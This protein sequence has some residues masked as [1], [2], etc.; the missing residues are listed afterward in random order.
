ALGMPLATPG[1][2]FLEGWPGPRTAYAAP[3]AVAVGGPRSPLLG[4]K[5][6]A[7]QLAGLTALGGSGGDSPTASPAVRAIGSRAAGP[8]DRGSAGEGTGVG[9]D[10]AFG[11]AL[12]DGGFWNRAG[13]L[14]LNLSALQAKMDG[15]LL[16][17]PKGGG[18]LPASGPRMQLAQ[19]FTAAAPRAG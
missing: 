3:D 6:S 9:G 10:G 14:R 8:S 13:G 16:T 7:E 5:P 17:T 15:D 2:I 1:M 18:G 12:G 11:A 19:P 4:E